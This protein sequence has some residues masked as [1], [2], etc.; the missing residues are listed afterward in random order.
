MCGIFGYIGNKNCIP[1]IISGLEKLEY[2]G[3]DSAGM[4]YIRN[5]SVL[6]I[7]KV[8]GKVQNLKEILD[9]SDFSK[10]GI[11]HTRWAT[12]GGISVENAHPHTDCKGNIVVVHNGIIENYKELKELLINKG[13]VFKSQTDTEVIPHLLEEM[14]DKEEIGLEEAVKE[15]FKKLEGAFALLIMDKRNPNILYALRKQSPLIVGFGIGENFI[16]SDIPALGDY[17]D[18]FY[19]LKDTQMAKISANEIKVYDMGVGKYIGVEPIRIPQDR[20]RAE[21]NGYPHFMLKEIFEQPLVVR[22]ILSTVNKNRDELQIEDIKSIDISWEK[23]KKVF[24]VACG[25][26]YHAGY[27]AKFLWEEELPYFIEVELASQM[28]HRNLRV[29]DETLFITISQSGETADVISTLRKVKEKG[30]KVLSL[31]NNPQSTVAR[32]SDYFINLRAGIEI[33]VAATKTFMAEI[34]YLGLLKEYVKNK[35]YKV[36]IDLDKWNMLPTYLENYLSN[37]KDQVFE[38]AKKYYQKKNFL[39]LARGRNFPLALEGA[40]KLKEISYI[41]AEGIPAGEMKHG[42]IALLDPETPVFG[43]AYK[44]DAYSKMI[45][46]LEEAKARRAPII[47][48]GNEKDKKLENLVDDLIPVPNID[49]FYYPYMGVMVLQLFAYYVA[50]LLGR[51]IDQP[52]NLAKSVTVE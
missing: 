5:D 37:I 13:H 42:P 20:I 22:R 14:V 2:R 9:F 15:L 19:Y 26:S 43:I 30:F 45:N 29:P 1:F 25:T 47:A 52:R 33:G 51:E 49:P 17:T 4:A 50:D 31:V 35:L 8:V 38:T 27:Y 32:E 6:E 28:H 23:I 3:Y 7:K 11:G 44:D 21:K 16:A 10:V 41:H 18:R 36:K 39:Y 48:I 40:L 12:H 24:I 34:V 46:N